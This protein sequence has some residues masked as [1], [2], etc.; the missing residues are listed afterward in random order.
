MNLSI[1]PLTTITDIRAC[2]ALQ[3][4]VWAMPDDLEVVP[5][6]LLVTVQRNG[7]LLLG[8]FDGAALVGFVF[9]FPGRSAEGKLVHCSHM[10]G[11]ASSYRSQGVGYRLKLAQ[12]DHVLEQGVDL[13]TWT[14]DPLESRNAYLNIHKLGCVCGTYVRDYY[15]PLSDGLSAGLPT[16]RFQVEWWI[17]SARVQRRLA[18]LSST[19]SADPMVQILATTRTA[20]GYLAPGR[21]KLET[22]APAIRFE[23]PVNY[24][25][26]KAADAALALEWRLAVRG[27]SEVC[28][29]AGYTVADFAHQHTPDGGRSFYVLEAN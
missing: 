7:G 22:A 25:A 1:R 4:Q 6:H 13:I 29:A 18:G 21:V 8:A 14:Y 23:I 12:R 15:G 3:R 16:D 5:L 27:I 28:F 10:M 17:G 11:V 19:Q 24:Q 20:G 2:E 26:L 9:G